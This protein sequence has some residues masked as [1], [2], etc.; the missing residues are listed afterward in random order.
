MQIL[1]AIDA[2]QNTYF[3]FKIQKDSHEMNQIK[4]C[5]TR[6][7]DKDQKVWLVPYSAA[8][9]KMIMTKMGNIKYVVSPEVIKIQEVPTYHKH[10][11]LK[12]TTTSTPI[13]KALKPGS[14]LSPSH[15]D[16]L[17]KMKEL[18]IV[19]R[20]QPNTQKSYLSS[21]TEFLAYYNDKKAEDLTIDDIRVFMLHKIKVDNIKEETQN[22]LINGIK[23]Y[24]EKV[25]KREKFYLYD[26][27]PRRAKK[28]PGFLSKEETV[29]LLTVTENLKHRAILQLIYSA[30]L[31]LSELTYLKVRNIKWDMDIIE[32]KCAKGK[33]DRISKLAKKVKA[34][35]TEY[36]EE[37]KPKY[38]LFEGQTGGKYSDR[39]VQHI[40]QNAV[41][42]SGVDENATVHTLRHT[43]A[44]H[45]ILDG[46]DLRTVQEYLGHNSPETTAIYT[47]ITDKMKKDVNSPLDNLDF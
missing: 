21:M 42:K 41:Q 12:P 35:L 22:G 26:L 15:Q 5:P 47:H 1:K 46:V 32:I 6:Y 23:F 2:S 9:W 40:M 29:K 11:K 18:L 33:K 30:G 24:F 39:S 31:R 44:T 43:F 8:N 17:L 16:A 19:K 37:Y 38:Y 45:M 13:K 20:Y 28:L 7:W 36:I 14:A 34:L 3:A 4:S 10:P 27:R 25:E